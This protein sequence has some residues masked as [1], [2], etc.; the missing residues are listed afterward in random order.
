MASRGSRRRSVDILVQKR[1]DAKAAKRFFR[2]LI[3]GL[4]YAPRKIVTDKLASYGAAHAEKLPQ[5][6]HLR[7]RC[8]NN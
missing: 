1:R 7:G 6:T 4:R 5:V 3:K 8:L 2:K